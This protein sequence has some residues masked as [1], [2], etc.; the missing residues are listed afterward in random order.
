MG[1]FLHARVTMFFI[2]RPEAKRYNVA[3]CK[4]VS[5]APRSRAVHCL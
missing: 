3:S 5:Y 1:V 2:M 4:S